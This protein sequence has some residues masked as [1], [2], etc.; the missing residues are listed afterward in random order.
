[1]AFKKLHVDRYYKYKQVVA[2][3]KYF[4]GKQTRNHDNHVS[5]AIIIIN[6]NNKLKE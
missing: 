2:H 3:Q 1:L 5:T 4:V 6:N